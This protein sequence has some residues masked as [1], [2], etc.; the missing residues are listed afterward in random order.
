VDALIDLRSAARALS[1]RPD[2]AI[3]VGLA[4][5]RLRRRAHSRHLVCV[6]GLMPVLLFATGMAVWWNRT[7]R[8]RP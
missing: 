2:R 5:G 1:R 7:I 3:D 8:R 4:C 6:F